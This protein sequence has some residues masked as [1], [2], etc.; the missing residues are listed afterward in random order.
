ML[1]LGHHR[2]LF[3]SKHKTTGLNVQV[4][5]DLEGNPIWIS[6]PVDGRDHDV[7][8]LAASRLLDGLGPRNC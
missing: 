7:A 4:L 2:Q 5:Y 1:D 3:S 8:A 6:G